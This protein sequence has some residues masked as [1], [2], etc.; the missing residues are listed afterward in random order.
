MS[1][2]KEYD[3]EWKKKNSDK[4]REY[5][6]E[7]RKKNPGKSAEYS[8][9]L[10]RKKGIE[11]KPEFPEAKPGFFVCRRCHSEKSISEF[12]KN[13]TC[14]RGHGPYCK[15]CVRNDQ[16]ERRR[17]KGQ[18]KRESL[19]VDVDEGKK[20]CPNCKEVKPAEEFRGCYCQT[21]RDDKSREWAAANPDKTKNY[22]RK[23][24]RKRELRLKELPGRHSPED[25]EALKTATG[26]KCLCCGA[27]G[28]D[29]EL[30]RDHVV[31]LSK[32][33]TDDISNIQPLCASCN[34][35]KRARTID[36]RG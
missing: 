26:N 10:R 15:L 21:C 8:I 33:G 24:K 22:G 4:V 19:D 9:R 35:K 32:G 23:A 16:A 28:D 11:P 36:Y 30:T 3:K 29:V 7:W 5:N 1:D 2:K 20:Y 18:A 17:E 31:P 12:V 14:E 6:R 34:S 27:S 13:N 25:W